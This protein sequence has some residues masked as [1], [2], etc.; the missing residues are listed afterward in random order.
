MLPRAA[1]AVKPSAVAGQ[2][3]SSERRGV[4]EQG[5]V[6]RLKQKLVQHYWTFAFWPTTTAAGSSG[7]YLTARRWGQN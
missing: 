6:R 1:D 2:L 5:T 4:R 7:E 3:Y